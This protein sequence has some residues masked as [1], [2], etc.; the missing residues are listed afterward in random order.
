MTLL[1]ERPPLNPYDSSQDS[2]EEARDSRRK[3]KRRKLAEESSPADWA[4]NRSK[5]EN[6]TTTDKES[7]EHHKSIVMMLENAIG[8]VRESWRNEERF[9]EEKWTGFVDG[10][11]GRWIESDE[12]KE[13]KELDLVGLKEKYEVEDST[14][15]DGEKIRQI[16]TALP[17]R[18]DEL[19]NNSIIVNGSEEQA[20]VP[21][22]EGEPPISTPF[23]LVLPPSS[24]FYLSSFSSSWS[25]STSPISLLG[26]ERGGFDLVIM[27]FVSP[28]SP[29]SN[30]LRNSPD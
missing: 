22:V 5:Q 3:R 20:I 15:E 8:Q 11:E 29:A 25:A 16:D 19:V 2:T 26:K 1:L 18:L 7:E 24:G 17:L 27:E 21:L 30:L 13:R 14:R 23:Q 4:I 6:K 12:K 9:E 28:L 10:K